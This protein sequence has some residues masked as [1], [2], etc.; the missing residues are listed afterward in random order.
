MKAA[1]IEVRIW[2]SE[3]ADEFDDRNRIYHISFLCST[4]GTILIFCQG[5]V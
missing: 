5:K 3:L 4:P 1:E 2:I